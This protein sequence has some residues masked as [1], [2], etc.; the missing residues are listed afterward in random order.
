MGDFEANDQDFSE[1]VKSFS[2]YNTHQEAMT[3]QLSE[4]SLAN[5]EL[6]ANLTHKESVIDQV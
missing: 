2:Q 5:I 6:R 1:L 3:K 4:L